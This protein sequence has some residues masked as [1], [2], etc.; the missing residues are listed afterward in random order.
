[1]PLSVVSLLATGA[2]ATKLASVVASETTMALVF[3]FW[4]NLCLMST[5]YLLETAFV[6]RELKGKIRA[7][8]DW[9]TGP[10][11]ECSA[12]LQQMHDGI[13]HIDLYN[14]YATCIP[15]LAE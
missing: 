5:E 9:T 12:L 14:M 4:T 1:M 13:G 10:S 6:D 8:C 7:T 11:S 2:L 15:C 3:N